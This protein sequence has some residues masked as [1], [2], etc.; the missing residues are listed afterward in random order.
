MITYAQPHLDVLHRTDIASKVKGSDVNLA[1]DE[2]WLEPTADRPLKGKV[3][4]K[5]SG[6]VFSPGLDQD[7]C[8]YREHLK[9][10]DGAL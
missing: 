7:V 3:Y 9:E 1:A 8:H 5:L 4:V 10:H 6:G 2:K